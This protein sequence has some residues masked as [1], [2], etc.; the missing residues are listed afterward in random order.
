MALQ[1]QSI[2]VIHSPYTQATGTPIQF[3]YAEGTEGTVEICAPFVEGLADLEGFDRIWLLY[4]C[5][6][7]GSPRMRVIPYRDTREHGLFATRAPARPNPIGLSC[8]ELVRIER[9]VL[10]IRNLDILDGTPL[11]DIKPYVPAFD[12]F[13]TVRTGWLTKER[14]GRMIADG[15]FHRRTE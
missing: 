13:R 10:H 3:V 14:T 1:M 7:S 12:S 5:H 6:R 15:R 8:V 9:H 2:G 11:L 4:W